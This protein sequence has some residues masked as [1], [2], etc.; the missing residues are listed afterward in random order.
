MRLSCRFLL[1]V[2]HCGANRNRER[3]LLRKVIEHCPC[4]ISSSFKV[5]KKTGEEMEVVFSSTP[6]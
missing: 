4:D 2:H 6:Q 5:G 1:L 3:C